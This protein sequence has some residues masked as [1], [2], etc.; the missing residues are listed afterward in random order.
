MSEQNY[1]TVPDTEPDTVTIRDIEWKTD[2]LTIYPDPMID[3]GDDVEGAVFVTGET[4]ADPHGTW[5]SS[6]RPCM[7][8]ELGST[9]YWIDEYDA[10]QIRDKLEPYTVNEWDG[11]NRQD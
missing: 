10:G 7:P 11:G 3:D 4:V 5:D 6:E 1:T 8:D 2:T 9:C